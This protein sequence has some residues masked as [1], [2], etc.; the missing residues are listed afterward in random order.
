[1]AS[2]GEVPAP[3]SAKPEKPAAISPEVAELLGKGGTRAQGL[4]VWLN[5][6]R[7]LQEDFDPE[8]AVADLRRYVGARGTAACFAVLI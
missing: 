5:P 4:P 3:A 7:F 2:V 8:E 1:M 6:D